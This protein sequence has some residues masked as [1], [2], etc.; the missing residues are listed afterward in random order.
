VSALLF[1]AFRH[2]RFGCHTYRITEPLLRSVIAPDSTPPAEPRPPSEA[3][4][5]QLPRNII[6]ARVSDDVAPEPVDGFFFSAPA[7]AGSGSAARIDLLFALGL[8]P[9]RPGL[10]LFDIS[11][12]A[13]AQLTEWATVDAR[14]EG[15]D[16]ANVLPGGELQ[17][18]HAITTGAEALKLA[19]L[20]FARIA[21]PAIA[22]ST[23]EEEGETVH[24]PSHG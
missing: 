9:G 13:A 3:G 22:W 21:D 20:C 15:E 11:L 10:S 18:Y 16:F 23:A 19:A 14:P 12:D 2:W 24:I 6:W 7:S 1:S 8:R 5:V 4:Y 17:G